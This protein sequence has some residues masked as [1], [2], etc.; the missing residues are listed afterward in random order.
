MWHFNSILSRIVWLHVLA[1]TLASIAIPATAYFL[2]SSTAESYQNRALLTHAD[3]I[4]T[5][6]SS[7]PNGEWKLNLPAEVRA[8][9]MR[10]YNG[11]A[12]AI[13]DENEK[14][15]FSSVDGDA[16]LL[17]GDPR[18]N[19]AHFF[20]ILRGKAVYY[21]ASLPVERAGR[22][23]W[24]QVAQDL[25]HPDVIVDDI[26]AAFLYRVGWII[27]P[28]LLVLLLFDIVIVRR[29]IRPVLDASGRAS[30][31]GPTKIDVRLPTANM[32]SE[33]LPLVGAVNQALDRLERGF[34]AQRE[35][36]A[37][38]AHELRTPL[39]V[40]RARVDA[41]IEKPVADDLRPTIDAI[42]RIVNQLLEIEELETFVVQ[43]DEVADLQ[44]VAAGVV[45]FIAPI[46]LAQGKNV[47]LTGA[48]FPVWVKGNAEALSHAIRNVVENAV[49]HTAQGTTVE[50]DIDAKGSVKI[51]DRGPGIPE[52]E[53][54]LIFRRF[55]RGDRRRARGAGLGLSIVSRIV[56]AHAGKI[57]VE[58]R[59]D[60]GA[61]FSLT[62]V[63]AGI[64]AEKR[65]HASV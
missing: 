37:D 47:A 18:D 7:S 40:L 5:Y 55:W 62:F 30:A 63:R 56:D 28:I 61:A 6:L 19:V 41:L 16:K 52:S 35:F 50:V 3:A 33:I 43:P 57:T 49:N 17:P 27:L 48:Q 4:S 46:V 23:V 38:A 11:F 21:G 34:R 20:H 15:L 39:A 10:G 53:R 54:E 51:L 65:A 42:S 36:T 26:V 64:A 22:T 44:S 14:V 60:G 45:A 25:E 24:I 32:P 58:N 9:Y 8:L 13:I 31:I 59:P 1:V 2:L 29:A 12:F